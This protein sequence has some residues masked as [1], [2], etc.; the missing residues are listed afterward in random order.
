VSPR[1]EALHPQL[2]ALF[3]ALD[4]GR[5]GKLSRTN[6]ACERIHDEA[7]YLLGRILSKVVC[8]GQTMDFG[9]FLHEWQCIAKEFD[10]A[11]LQRLLCTQQRGTEAMLH[12]K[13]TESEQW[14]TNNGVESQLTTGRSDVIK[15]FEFL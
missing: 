12:E 1:A 3:N 9:G 2:R 14:D 8:R 10:A 15:R 4:K 5:T 7:Q 11:D 13:D 6:C